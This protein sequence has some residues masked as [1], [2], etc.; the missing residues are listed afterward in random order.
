MSAASFRV[1][2]FWHS[3]EQQRKKPLRLIRA[4]GMGNLVRYLLRLDSLTDMI[5]RAG[6]KL[7]VNGKPVIMPQPE[8]AIDVDTPRDLIL[9]EQILGARR[10]ETGQ[11]AE[12]LS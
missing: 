9:V 11:A 7:G 2:D 5:N 10:A 6:R 8:A 12:A 4:F 1:L 3:I